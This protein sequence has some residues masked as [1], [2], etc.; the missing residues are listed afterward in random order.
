M[1]EINNAEVENKLNIPDEII[2]RIPESEISQFLIA[3]Q[4]V[5]DK[6]SVI[7]ANAFD[8]IGVSKDIINR[9]PSSELFEFLVERGYVE[10][11]VHEHIGEEHN[12]GVPAPKDLI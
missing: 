11:L 5:I 3:R 10:I 8:E 9:I 6:K 7:P 12:Q 1:T 4:R 2:N